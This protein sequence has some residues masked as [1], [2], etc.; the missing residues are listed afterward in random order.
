MTLLDAEELLH[1]GLHATRDNQPEAALKYLKESLALEPDNAH[2][3]YLL[4]AN[5]AQLGMY[6][7]ASSLFE[8]TL[9]LAPHE[10]SAAF[11]LGLLH[12]MRGNAEA[13]RSEWTRLEDL[14]EANALYCYKTALLALAVDDFAAAIE[15]FDAGF[16]VGGSNAALDADMRRFRDRIDQATL[17]PQAETATATTP[18]AISGDFVLSHYQH[19]RDR[20]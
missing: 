13:A 17:E 11:Q 6:D 9:E 4:A 10:H 8:R 14:G 7:R 12:L 2:A 1:L 15:W 18:A 3:T 19:S 16:A 20:S 5:Y